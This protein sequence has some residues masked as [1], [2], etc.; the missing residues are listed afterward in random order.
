MKTATIAEMK[1]QLSAYVR[2]STA[3][4]IVLTRSGKPV[5]VLVGIE[6]E[7]E[8]ERLLMAY[9]P[10]LRAILDKSR[11]Q[12]AEGKSMKHEEFW[13]K[14]ESKAAARSKRRR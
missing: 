14:V 4:P 13:A 10:K 5:A 2:A 1:A 11:Q 6:D 8:I 9:S 7:E 3:G 12:I